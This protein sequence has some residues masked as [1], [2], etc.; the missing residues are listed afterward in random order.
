MSSGGKGTEVP[1]ERACAL[2]WTQHRDGSPLLQWVLFV[3][4]RTVC[5]HFFLVESPL[6]RCECNDPRP[7]QGGG[8]LGSALFG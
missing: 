6:F 5:E 3:L 8:G 7:I 4:N 2:P 1:E